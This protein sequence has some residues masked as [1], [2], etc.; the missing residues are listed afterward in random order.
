MDILIVDTE[1]TGLSPK[2]DRVVEVAGVLYSLEHA[3][4]VRSFASLIRTPDGNAAEEINGISPALLADAATPDADEVWEAMR[5]L[6]CSA[7]CIVAHHADFDHEFCVGRLDVEVLDADGRMRPIPWVCSMDDIEWPRRSTSRQ[8]AQAGGG[9][10][11]ARAPHARIPGR[12]RQVS[13]R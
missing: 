3:S 6:A 12:W 9:R 7:E 8:L 1:T 2:T 11:D 13:P 5:V 10:S 4:V